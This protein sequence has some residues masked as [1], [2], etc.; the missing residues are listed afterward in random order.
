MEDRYIATLINQEGGPTFRLILRGLQIIAV[1]EGWEAEL[2]D[3]SFDTAPSDQ[4]LAERVYALY[5]SPEWEVAD[6]IRVDM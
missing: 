5:D 2:S 1:G 3:G 4:E 6:C